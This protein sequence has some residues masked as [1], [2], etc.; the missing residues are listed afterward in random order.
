MIAPAYG[1]F[2]YRDNVFFMETQA[3]MRA[4]WEAWEATMPAIPADA[5]VS[6]GYS[7]KDMPQR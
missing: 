7:V 4:A 2:L 6:L 3:A 5:T 1:P